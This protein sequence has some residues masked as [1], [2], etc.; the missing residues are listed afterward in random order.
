MNLSADRQDYELSLMDN[1]DTQ[2]HVLSLIVMLKRF[3]SAS[4]FEIP[5]KKILQR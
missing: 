1:P 2:R 5:N 4:V 3:Y